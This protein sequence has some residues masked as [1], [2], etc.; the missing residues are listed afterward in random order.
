VSIVGRQQPASTR[1]PRPDDAEVRALFA[2]YRATGDPRTRERLVIRHRPLA[3]SLAAG[4]AR[5][6]EPFDDLFQVACLGLLKAVD[7]YD[8]ERTT[9]FASYAVP[10]ILGELKRY[11][12]DG[13]WSVRVPH[14]VHDRAMR[15]R[16][17]RAKLPPDKRETTVRKLAAALDMPEVQVRDALGALLAYETVSLEGARGDD[18]ERKLGDTLGA[19]DDGFRRVEQRCDVDELLACLGTRERE[20]VWLR[21]Y[22]NLSQ[23]EIAARV[24]VSQMAISRLLARCLPQLRA[25]AEARELRPA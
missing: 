23:R 7:R 10:T 14:T 13:T 1:V 20:I 22:E 24:G 6:I 19:T 2:H 8:P 16:A 4:Y 9:A 5:G 12:R 17:L 15:V 21:F 11:F 3:R 18:E 25:R